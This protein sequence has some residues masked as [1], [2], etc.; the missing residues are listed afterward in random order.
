MMPTYIKYMYESFLGIYL[1]E[2]PRHGL[3]GTHVYLPQLRLE[4]LSAAICQWVYP[5]RW[6][7]YTGSILPFF[8]NGYPITGL[9]SCVELY[10]LM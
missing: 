5:S 10:Y 7:R 4:P 6:A 1:N 3:R 9:N 2:D 8:A